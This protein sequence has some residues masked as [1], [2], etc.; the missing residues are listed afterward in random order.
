MPSCPAPVKK[1]SVGNHSLV[2]LIIFSTDRAERVHERQDD[3]SHKRRMKQSVSRQDQ[4]DHRKQ[5]SAPSIS[6][7]GVPAG[8]R[9]FHKHTDS[10]HSKK[11]RGTAI[12]TSRRNG[13]HKV[14][15]DTAEH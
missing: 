12:P 8:A 6:Q 7:T 5:P 13:N 14:M 2:L 15:N 10:L 1:I 11:N 9:S 4:H 3:I